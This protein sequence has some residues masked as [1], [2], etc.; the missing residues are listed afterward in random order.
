MFPIY[1]SLAAGSPPLA[2]L[3]AGPASVLVL[4]PGGTAMVALSELALGLMPGDDIDALLYDP[5]PGGTLLVSLA[6]GSP[7]CFIRCMISSS[8]LVMLI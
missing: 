6:A 8:S 4:N 3:G 7:S 2:L 1:F 5:N